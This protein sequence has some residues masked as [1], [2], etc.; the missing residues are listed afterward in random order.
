VLAL[1]VAQP[2]RA[3]SLTWTGAASQ[4]WFN[5]GNWNG[6]VAPTT[7]DD[8][9]I[10]QPYANSLNLNAPGAQSGWVWV[11]SASDGSMT[12]SNGATL[13][14]SGAGRIGVANGVTGAVTVTG[15]G[16]SWNSG[17]LILGV[18]A[19]S[20]GRM[21]IENGASVSVPGISIGRSGSGNV[22]VTGTGSSLTKSGGGFGIGDGAGGNG[23]LTI[24]ENGRVTSDG[25][26]AV[27]LGG[28]NGML[29]IGTGTGSAPGVLDAPSVLLTNANQ[30][31]FFNHGAS[32]YIFAPQIVGVGTVTIH[33]GT[34]ILTAQHT[35]TGETI[36]D[37]G[38]LRVDGSIA[39]S[40]LTRVDAGGTLGGNGTV[41]NTLINGGTLAPGNSIG[42][43]S[44]QGNL[45]FTAAAS[46]LVEVSPSSADRTNVSGTATLGGAAVNASFAS[47]TYVGKRY[48]I[49][50]AA[51]VIGTFAGPVNTNLPQ[52]FTSSLSYTGSNVYLDLM[53]NYVPPAAPGYGNG[54]NRNQ[55]QVAN[56]L[57]DSFNTAGGIPLAFGA[58]T[59]QGLT[60]V[61]GETATGAQQA[62]FNAMTQFIGVMTDP[63]PAGR[64]EV[65]AGG[66]PAFAQHSDATAYAGSRKRSNAEREAYAMAANVPPRAFEPRWNIWGAGFGGGQT[67]DGNAAQGSNPSTSRL[68]AVAAGADYLL[69][70][71]TLAGFALAGGGTSFTVSNGGSGR[72]DLFQAGAFVRHAVGA[73]Y[74]TAAAAYGW[75]DIA[76]D[77]TVT[78][79]GLDQL[80]ANFKANTYSGR[81]EGGYRLVAPSLGGVGVTPYAAGQVTAIDLPGYAESVLSGTGNF[82]LG[83]NAKVVTDSRSELGFRTDKAFSLPGS[84]LTLRGRLAW[85][86]DFNPD[87]SVAATF[88]TLPGASFV[89]DGARQPA[90]SALT[91]ASAEL[92]WLNGW[93]AAASFEGDF[94]EVSRSYAGKGMV[95]YAW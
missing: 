22:L 10:Q 9:T 42:A 4:D 41:G 51:Q 85:A 54:L 68:G 6:G 35:Y 40:S 31:L 63:F 28:G 33:A 3:A 25:A 36:V 58:L 23:L 78:A 90:D 20:T 65:A 44:V 83:Y 24:A 73:A 76:T 75:Q 32:D 74:I 14:A 12:I 13:T 16:S 67:T 37:G 53:L 30:A 39:A 19:G 34:T 61:S 82:A 95:R 87:R 59:P 5:V 46:Y 45:V 1:T 62:T 17:Y 56:A 91:T 50:S 80:Y 49:L 27:G 77:R 57:I 81:L 94:S 43:L 71:N 8:V 29:Q 88:Q 84:A 72:S 55:Q 79:A 15:T 93:S 60:Q 21:T 38:T 47:G 92:N 69:S 26:I 64:G 18:D 48:T 66:A 52:N 2:G 7:N 86:H 70:P 11:G 89:V